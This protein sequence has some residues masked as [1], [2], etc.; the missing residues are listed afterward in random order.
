MQ[1][2]QKPKNPS[3]VCR[4]YSIISYFEP[5]YLNRVKFEPVLTPENST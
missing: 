2:M 4:K 3:G 1:K 5:G